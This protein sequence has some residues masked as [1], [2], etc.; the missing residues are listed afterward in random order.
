MAHGWTRGIRPELVRL[1]VEFLRGILSKVYGAQ[2]AVKIRV[3]PISPISE[4]RVAP[5][6]ANLF[7]ATLELRSHDQHLLLMYKY[8]I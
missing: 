2:V 3:A 7:Q 4:N 6:L 8:P 1:E 5:I